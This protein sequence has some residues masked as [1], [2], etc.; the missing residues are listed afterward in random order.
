MK[1]K[2][3]DQRRPHTKKPYHPPTKQLNIKSLKSGQV[4]K[5]NLRGGERGTALE[6]SASQ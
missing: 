2:T 5:H 4:R 3:N 6:R 1:K